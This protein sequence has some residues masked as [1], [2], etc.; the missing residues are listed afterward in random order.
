MFGTRRSPHSPRVLRG[1]SACFRARPCGRCGR[2]SCSRGQCYSSGAARLHDLLLCRCVHGMAEAAFAAAATG[3]IGF[4][5]VI[6]FLII[7]LWTPPHFWALALN[8]SDEYTRAGVPMLPVVAGR[9]ATVQQIRCV[10][11]V[12]VS[13]LPWVLG[14]AGRFYGATAVIC[15][16]NSTATVTARWR[17]LIKGAFNAPVLLRLFCVARRS[18]RELCGCGLRPFRLDRRRRRTSRFG[19]H[20]RDAWDR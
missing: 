1:G 13:L 5:P 16:A 14:F 19:R 3:D 6:L 2:C 18:G 20:G 7:F 10:L 4:E 17:R 12:P 11:L 15:G 9:A 8:R